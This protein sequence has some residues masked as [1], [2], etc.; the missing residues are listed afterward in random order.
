MNCNDLHNFE[1]LQFMPVRANKQPIVKGWQTFTGKHDLSNCE[2]VG[3]VCGK[4][5]G[6]LEV[7]DIDTKYDI[8]GTIYERYK[9]LIHSVDEFLL[10]KIVVQRTKSG[11]YHFIYRCSVISGNLKLANR[12][13]TQEEKDQTFQKTYQAELAASQPDDKAR[14]KAEKAAQNDKVR[15][16]FET[17]GEGGQ[18]VCNPSEGYELVFRDWYGISEITP[19]QRD[20][21]HGIARQFN[22]VVEEFTAPKLKTQRIKGMS[23]YDD[24]NERGDVIGLLE[25]HGWKIVGQKGPRT[26]FL[27]PGQTTSHTSGNYDASKKWFSVFTTSSDFEPEKAYLPYAVFAVLECNKNF[28]EAASKL[29]DLGYGDRHEEVKKE[30]TR[31]IGS[32]INADDD[33]YSFLATPADYDDY[34]QSVIDGTLVQGLSTGIPSLDEHFLFKE[35][36]LVMSN[37]HDNTGKSVII[38]Y[39]ALLSAILHGWN[40]IIFSSENTLGA[41]MRKM[42]QFYWGKPLQ[43]KFAMS[44]AEYD[45]AKKFVEE[46]F[47]LIRSEEDMFNYKDIINMMKKL[48]KKKKYHAGMIDPYNSLKIDLSGFSKLST[49]EFHYEALS[50]FKLFGK[51][52]NFGLF[53][54]H[55]AVTAALRM[56][57]GEKK[58]PVAPQKAD[59]EGGGKVANKADDFLTIHRITQH[60]TDWMVTELHVRKIKDTET[61]GRVTSIDSPVKLEMYRNGCGFIERL[62]DGLRSAIDPIQKWH[63]RDNPAPE[64]NGRA[65]VINIWTP[66]KNDLEESP[67]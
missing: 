25:S 65:P 26:I 16:L 15:V 7:I 64:A 43:G 57:D 17:R 14:S 53:I 39:L 34:L 19:E 58:Y 38:W 47:S 40:W 1:G 23:P 59:T 50:D 37:G 13:T 21:L 60:P 55:H 66:Y 48:M 52:Y 24:Y 2:A 22:E 18:I 20:I 63:N 8:T 29:Y 46:H 31:V 32:R 41:F 35:G 67:F 33:D 45:I 30:S 6:G 54:N 9:R 3:L 28:S 62:E 51:K 10:N 44:R 12:G 61:G 27:R 11:G 36:N 56:K 42:I 5:S 49:H 4:L